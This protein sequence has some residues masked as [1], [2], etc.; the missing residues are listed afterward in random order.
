[1]LPRGRRAL[2]GLGVA[3][4]SSLTSAQQPDDK[5]TSSPRTEGVVT[6]L[7]LFAGT[8]EGLWRSSDWGGTWT[9][10]VGPPPGDTLES[11][12]AA[13]ALLPLGP[14]VYVGGD[15]GLYTSE[16]FGVSWKR[17][18]SGGSALCIMPSRYPQSDPTVF[19]GTASGL[20][21][22]TDG[23]T[24]FAPTALGSVPVSRLEWPGPA[25]VVATGHGVAISEDAAHA[26]RGGGQ[27]LPDGE[28]RGLAV[29][30]YFA[31]DPVLFAGGSYGVYRSQDAGR[32]WKPAGLS[33]RTVNDLVW[34]GPFLYA[35]G[36]G[37]VFRSEDIGQTWTTLSEGLAG[38]EG[39]RLLFPHAPAAG[40][41]AFLGTDDGIFRTVDGGQTWQR[42]GL[43][44]R[45]IL[46]LATFP[47]PLPSSGKRK[48]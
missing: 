35:A 27:G 43:E 33:R 18:W 40:L 39:R 25:L 46:S 5:N 6:S 47:P 21:K 48:K 19:V 3:L 41:E 14:Q 23:G 11:L 1:M 17:L 31:V 42:S 15:G 45:P 2:G 37:G 7:T 34:L 32:T 22:S 8:S 20:Q 38:R 36:E 10:V 16:D 44:G 4:L 30:S 12:G 24:S 9:R 28:V 26:F 29:S 13:R